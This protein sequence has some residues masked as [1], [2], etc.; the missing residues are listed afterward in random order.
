MASP[1]VPRHARRPHTRPMSSPIG[2]LGPSRRRRLAAALSGLSLLVAGCSAQSPNRAGAPDP[3]TA[4]GAVLDT[5]AV[6]AEVP[7][8]VSF[9]LKWEWNRLAL[10][11]D[12]LS[13]ITGGSTFYELVW[14]DVERTEGERDWAAV[15]EVVRGAT[16]LGYRMHLKI[17]VGS[18]WATGER[19]EGRGRREKTAS[20]MPENMAD[21]RDFVTEAV[22]RYAPRGVS[23]WAVENEVNEPNF[24]AASA[25]DY[26]R[27]VEVAA[28]AIRGADPSALVFDAGVSSTAY[29]FGLGRWLLDQDRPTEAVAAYQQ[30][31]ARRFSVRP[32]P[33]ADDEQSLRQALEGEKGER[34]LAFLDAGWQLAAAGTI[35]RYQLHFYEPW[36][37]AALLGA[38]LR[39][40]LP[41]AMPYETWEAGLFWPDGGDTPAELPG[42]TVKVVASLL[43]A[44]TSAV[45]WLPTSFDPGGIRETEIRWALFGS[46][47]V[48]RPAWGAFS[49]LAAA[50]TGLNASRPVRT[51]AGVEGV[52]LSDGSRSV[53]VLWSSEPSRLPGPAPAGTKVTDLLGEPVAW[54]AA[55]LR[56]GPDPILVEAPVDLVSALMLAGAA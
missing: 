13:A 22:S 16:D 44:G 34:N 5:P 42:E 45:L 28:A 25:R 23:R 31:F 15:D 29:G 10:Y 24:W 26:V 56:V 11:D 38:F 20:L 21:Y 49:R 3:L 27:L 48:P 37:N 46:S 12:H 4:A 43:G 47:G 54:P 19:L 40:Q 39:D 6:T 35:D 30:Y 51:P 7:G 8:G 52:A 41:A 55:G 53:L 36:A 33:K 2:K 32:L 18:C 17:R 1:P 14:C 9:G 50:A